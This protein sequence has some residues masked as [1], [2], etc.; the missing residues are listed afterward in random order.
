MRHIR[1]IGHIGLM[2]LIGPMSLIGLMSCLGLMGCSSDSGEQEPAPAPIGTAIT[3]AARQGEEAVSQGA[4]SYRANEAAYRAYGANRRAATPLSEDATS[5][6]IWAYKNMDYNE[7]VYRDEQLVFPGYDVD[8]IN[9]SA[10]TTTTNTSGWEYILA[11]KPE[12]T[13]KYWDWGAAAY[14]FFAL[15]EYTS[16][17]PHVAYGPNDEYW[18]HEFTLTADATD[19]GAAPYFS[20]LWFSTGSFEDYPD[21]EFGKPVQLEFMKPFTRVRFL[22]IYAYE[23]E[24]IRLKNKAFKPSED[25]DIALKGTVTVT[26]PINGT[27]TRE[28][29]S[30]VPKE[31]PTSEEVLDAFTEEFIPE[32]TEK[33]YTVLPRTSQG[34]YTMHVEV[35]ADKKK[36]VVPAEYMTWLPGYSYTYIFK[37]TNEGG[38]EIALVESAVTPW[39]EMETDRVVYNW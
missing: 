25:S 6:K 27:K 22:F 34:S 3:F 1:H 39:S 17:E 11:G 2:R 14:R 10:A 21:K 12:Q 32:G 5:F 37:I 36:A 28:W 19:V 23:Q 24:G 18:A 16:H 15:T 38:V 20:K 31:S 8:H 26:Y 7:G 33:W 29:Y 35:N 4:R 30:A 9:N 13:I